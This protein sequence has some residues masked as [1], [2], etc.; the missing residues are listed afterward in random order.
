MAQAEARQ[1]QI[2]LTPKASYVSWPFLDAN[3]L[4]SEEMGAPKTSG[5]VI[6]KNAAG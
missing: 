1:L 5:W 3:L 6:T 2:W 4:R